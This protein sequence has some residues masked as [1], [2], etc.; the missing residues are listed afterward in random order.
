MEGDNG[1]IKKRRKSLR[2][3]LIIMAIILVA[4]AGSFYIY[5]L[6]YYRADKVALQTMLDTEQYDKALT[7]FAPQSAPS[8]GLIFYPGGKV[9]SAAYAP[10][11]W[12]VS[13]NGMLCV[14]V[15]MPFHLAVF[16]T[17]AA[18]RVM[19][20]F[21]EIEHWYIA[22]HSLGGAMASSYAGSHTDRLNGLIMLG[23]Y[24]VNDAQIPTLALYGSEDGL[25]NKE[26]LEGTANVIEIPG[27][28]HAYF[29]NYGEQRGDG[30]ATITRE[31]Q[32]RITA[33]EISAFVKDND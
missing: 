26:K 1:M 23:A 7:V 20:A 24:P 5:T 16:D 27:G 25:L 2:I 8:S 9:E 33:Q 32:Q 19:D 13:E 6:D 30:A 11:L 21:P 28:N 3:V 31:E 4:L 17:N 14:L 15:D 10:L 12:R 29:G 22:G 18:D